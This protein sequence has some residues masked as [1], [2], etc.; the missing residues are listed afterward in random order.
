MTTTHT[1]PLSEKEG[2]AMTEDS[3][4]AWLDAMPV[5]DVRRRIERIEQELSDLETLERLR[6][7]RQPPLGQPPLE[8][9]PQPM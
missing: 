7:R 3:L 6:E 1:N 2:Q 9:G 4:E 5:E 8:E